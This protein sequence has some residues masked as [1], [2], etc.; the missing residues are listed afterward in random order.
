[1]TA[2]VYIFEGKN[3]ISCCC[4]GEKCEKRGWKMES[5]KENACRMGKN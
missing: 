5:K 4:F 1:L 3:S 2:E